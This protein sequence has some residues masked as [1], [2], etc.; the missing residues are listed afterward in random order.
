MQLTL[1]CVHLSAGHAC[2]WLAAH[3]TVW[4][5]ASHEL[6]SLRLP[7]LESQGQQVTNTAVRKTSKL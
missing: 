6:K 5:A 2:G 1:A 7:L 4:P 3:M